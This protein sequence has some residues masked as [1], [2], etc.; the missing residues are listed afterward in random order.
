M[1][2]TSAQT[3]PF[4]PLLNHFHL[5]R[6][7]ELSNFFVQHK[8]SASETVQTKIHRIVHYI[9]T[10]TWISENTLLSWAAKNPKQQFSKLFPTESP[11]HRKL[12]RVEHHLSIPKATFLDKCRQAFK[13]FKEYIHDSQTVGAVLP[14]SSALAKEIVSEIPKDPQARPRVILEI[15]PGTGSF[16]DKIIKR[17]NPKDTLHLVEFDKKFC[18][19]LQARY[20]HIPNV[21]V[22]H[23]S[24]LDYGVDATKKY[25]H[26]VS[27][28]PL[29]SFPT[30]MV[31]KIFEKY[32]ELSKNGAT[33]SYFDYRFLP[34]IKNFYLSE[35]E[36]KA[37][38]DILRQKELFYSQYGLRE[39][40]T[41]SNVPPA[42]I[43]HHRVGA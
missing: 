9:Q 6:P 41:F 27:G 24:I 1:I 25:D 13:F 42:R 32:K 29:N 12:F 20:K 2:I 3:G 10:K 30:E 18:L 28:L 15:G 26:I 21:R 43:L 19:Q 16:T 38:E 33:L 11:V 39:A 17:M 31:Q 40:T 23:Q 22:F 7:E 8:H 4:Q 37:F 5:T 34:K 36:K 14:S 35:E